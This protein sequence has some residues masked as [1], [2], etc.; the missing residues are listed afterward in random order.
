MLLVN[1]RLTTPCC[2][3]REYHK[4][5]HSLTAENLRTSELSP[6]E[7]SL[8]VE[9]NVCELR[10]CP[11]V[12]SWQ[13]VPPAE[14]PRG[15]R[16]GACPRAGDSVASKK[17]VVTKNASFCYHHLCTIFGSTQKRNILRDFGY[18]HLLNHSF[19]GDG[20]NDFCS[21]TQYSVRVHLFDRKMVV[22]K[23][24]H[25]SLPPSFR[26]CRDFRRQAPGRPRR[27][28]AI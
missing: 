19:G 25:F 22:T 21:K 12:R 16:A 24:Q 15:A 7:D 28:A 13:S 11:D 10:A 8:V 26:P 17:M 5:P 23:T 4:P 1:M 2:G 14:S 3:L 18:H 27:T 20:G 9:K 6:S